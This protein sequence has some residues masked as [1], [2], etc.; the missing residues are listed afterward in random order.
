MYKA[1]A[2]LKSYHSSGDIHEAT[3]Q[4]FVPKDH[5]RDASQQAY[6][7]VLVSSEFAT[8]SEGMIKVDINIAMWHL[9]K[10]TEGVMVTPKLPQPQITEQ[11]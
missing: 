2:S 4:F 1:E 9:Q 5:I 7:N 6:L 11:D 10:T 3:L 8:M